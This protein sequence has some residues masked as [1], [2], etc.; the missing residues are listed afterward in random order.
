MTRNAS[1]K[2]FAAAR[3][4]ARLIVGAL[5]FCTLLADA[6]A[7]ATALGTEPFV[8]SSRI[9]AL[10]NVMYV[11]DDSGSMSQDFLPDWA[12]PFE[13]TIGGV[14]TVVTPPHRFF[15]GAYNGT[16]Y[17]PETR[18]RP[19]VMYTNTG[20]L[21]TTTYP[22]QTGDSPATGGSATATAASPNWQAVKV[23]GYGI[24]STA[25][26]NLEGNAYSYSTVPGEYCDSIQLRN[27]VVAAAPTGAYIFPAKLRWCT[28]SVLA[29]DTT[30][31]AGTS[32]QASNIADTPANTANGVTNYTFARMPRPHT[33]T[34]TVNAPGTVTSVA[35][36]GQEILSADAAGLTSAD[37]ATA[38]ALQINACTYGIPVLSPASRCTAVGY[39]AVINLGLPNEITVT[40]PAATAATPGGDRRRNDRGRLQQRQRPRGAAC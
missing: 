12:G 24:Q 16:A 31:N 26:V 36:G 39:S 30:A 7:A 38:I 8:S 1:F 33:A 23:D 20:A 25:T 29:V 6:Q 37:V 2:T 4:F 5:C 21:D 35:V 15:N 28:T 22:S 10:P 3:K 9:N 27:C 32:C 19:P 34:I 14:L 11:L 40:A 17:N 13:A 18:Y